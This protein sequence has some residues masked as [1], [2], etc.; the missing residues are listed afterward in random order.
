MNRDPVFDLPR[1]EGESG[2]NLSSIPEIKREFESRVGKARR[3]ILLERLWPRL[4]GSASALTLFAGAVWSN[5]LPMLPP[6]GKIA[7]L[8]AFGIAAAAP[9]VMRAREYLVPRR[10]AI[11]RLDSNFEGKTHPA[12]LLADRLDE[13][14]DGVQQ[15]LWEYRL[16]DA[17]AQ[18]SGRLN[19]RKADL[20]LPGR[21]RGFYAAAVLTAVFAG[22][23]AGTDG[24]DRLRETFNFTVPVAP[25]PPLAVK[26]W[27][28]TPEGIKA[29]VLP[30]LTEKTPDKGLVAHK[31]STMTVLVYGSETKIGVN[32]E[33]IP[34]KKTIVPVPGSADPTA[35]EYEFPLLKE[36]TIIA[37]ERGPTWHFAVTPDRA[38]KVVLHGLSTD[39]KKPGSMQMRYNSDEDHGV[40]QRE[41]IITTPQKPGATPLPSWQ[42]PA[43]TVE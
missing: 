39:A 11:E 15:R 40:T 14:H 4:M 29:P 28:K 23:T 43:I 34:L 42:I 9:L 5:L 18:W 19:S 1:Q 10:A 7:S 27:V 30:D 22:I 25:L 21:K 37:I 2:R 32:G 31:T 36:K 41:V 12:H 17:W 3:S 8:A 26:A 13:K 38:P 24:P 6:A 33:I 20:S 16:A 35:F